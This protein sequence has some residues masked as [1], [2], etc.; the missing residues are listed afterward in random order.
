MIFLTMKRKT[1]LW[2][3]ILES[4]RGNKP[5]R[6]TEK[7]EVGGNQKSIAF[8]LKCESFQ[9]KREKSRVRLRKKKIEHDIVKNTDLT[10]EK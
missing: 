1:E 3:H 10:S 5:T 4:K 9:R 8:S 6:E 7:E 2:G